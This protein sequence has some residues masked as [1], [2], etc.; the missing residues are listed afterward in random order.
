M[1]MFQWSTENSL[2]ANVKENGKKLSKEIEIVKK[3][4]MDVT[5]VEFFKKMCSVGHWSSGCDR[6]LES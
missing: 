5:E 6:G 1:K 3:N 2:K 4:Q